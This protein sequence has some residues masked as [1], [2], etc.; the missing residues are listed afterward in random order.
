MISNAAKNM[1]ATVLIVASI[2]AISTAG[3]VMY[4]THPP[5]LAVVIYIIGCFAALISSCV[6]WWTRG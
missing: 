2:G 5:A 4:P 6:Y 3:P 1:L